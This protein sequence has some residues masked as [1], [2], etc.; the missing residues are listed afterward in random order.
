MTNIWIW[1]RA[2]LFVCLIILILFLIFL[3]HHT[4]VTMKFFKLMF[5]KGLLATYTMKFLKLMLFTLLASLTGR[6]YYICRSVAVLSHLGVAVFPALF[7]PLTFTFFPYFC[8]REGCLI[9]FHLPCR[10]RL[11]L[12]EY[13]EH[14]IDVDNSYEFIILIHLSNNEIRHLLVKPRTFDSLKKV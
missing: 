5:R 10:D 4:T 7:I 12:M 6:S 2:F 13:L 9:I 1:M 14:S 8:H 11:P 3:A